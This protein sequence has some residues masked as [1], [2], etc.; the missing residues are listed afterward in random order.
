MFS[1]FENFI[2][3]KIFAKFENITNFIEFGRISRFYQTLNFCQFC[4]NCEILCLFNFDV[5]E[6]VANFFQFDQIR[7]LKIL[8]PF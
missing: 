1:C 2:K 7:I 6:K 4:R 8:E 3:F 5:A